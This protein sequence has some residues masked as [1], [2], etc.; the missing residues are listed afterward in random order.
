MAYDTYFTCNIEVTGTT[1]LINKIVGN[2][3]STISNNAVFSGDEQL[4]QNY[5]DLEASA[6]N[7]FVTLGSSTPLGTAAGIHCSFWLFRNGAVMSTNNVVFIDMINVQGAGFKVH[8]DQFN[9]NIRFETPANN[10]SSNQ[11]TAS[12]PENGLWAH[13]YFYRDGSTEIKVYKNG[14]VENT[15]ALVGDA[16]TNVSTLQFMFKDFGATD[17]LTGA[18]CFIDEIKIGDNF[19]D[20]AV[21]E[22]SLKDRRKLWAKFNN[23][24]NDSSGY[25]FNTIN[26]AGGSPTFVAGKKGQ[27]VD[28]DG[29]SD[30]LIFAYSGSTGIAHIVHNHSMA[31]W[32]NVDT[33]DGVIQRIIDGVNYKIFIDVNGDLQIETQL[34]FGPSDI[35]INKVI[36]ARWYHVIYTWN[37]DDL[38]LRVYID[39]VLVFREDITSNPFSNFEDTNLDIG[40]TGGGAEF[41]DGQLD[42]FRIYDFVLNETE[43]K[44]V[45][46]WK[47]VSLNNKT[48]SWYKMS[49]DIKNAMGNF[50][51][52]IANKTNATFSTDNANNGQSLLLADGFLDIE[53]FRHS[54]IHED[55]VTITFWMHKSSTSTNNITII[56]DNNTSVSANKGYGYIFIGLTGLNNNLVIRVTRLQTDT[57]S[58]LSVISPAFL[59]DD[60]LT[61][62]AV[63]V[64]YGTKIVKTWRNSVLIDTFTASAEELRTPTGSEQDI[65]IGRHG[66]DFFTGRS[67]DIEPSPNHMYMRADGTQ[68]WI[69]H[70]DIADVNDRIYEYN[71]SVAFDIT[72]ATLGNNFDTS[73]EDTQPANVYF[74]TDGAKMFVAGST[75][76]DIFEYDLGTDFDV[77]SAVFNSNLLSIAFNVLGS[78]FLKDGTKLYVFVLVGAGQYRILQYNLSSGFDITTAVDSTNIFNIATS[79]ILRGTGINGAGDRFY[80]TDRTNDD[81]KEYTFGTALDISTLSFTRNIDVSPEDGNMEG[82]FYME[83]R[84]LL[85]GVGDNNDKL[86][87]YDVFDFP[88]SSGNID[89]LRFFNQQ[90]T[91]ADLI[92]I[93]SFREIYDLRINDKSYVGRQ[94]K[95]EYITSVGF[96]SGSFKG[97]I[98]D[99]DGIITTEISNGDDV[100]IY[101]SGF[102]VFRGMLENPSR[103]K[104]KILE[105]QGRDY[106]NILFNR[107]ILNKSF[108]SLTR[109]QIMDK[110]VD[111]SDALLTNDFGPI[112]FSSSGI[113]DI[114]GETIGTPDP[115]VVDFMTVAELFIRFSKEEDAEVYVEITE[116]DPIPIRYEPKEFE[117]S[118]IEI[119][120]DTPANSTSR[121]MIRKFKFS[122]DSKQ[123]KNVFPVFGPAS[124][125]SVTIFKDLDST[126]VHGEK[127]MPAIV[128]VNAISTSLQRERAEEEKRKWE[129]ILQKGS[130]TCRDNSFLQG[131]K[132]MQVTIAEEGLNRATLLILEAKHTNRPSS[133]IL[134]VADI[135]RASEEAL[136]NLISK[137]Q[138]VNFRDADPTSTQTLVL[139]VTYTY[140]YDFIFRISEGTTL[141]QEFSAMITT[142][143]GKNAL[144]D[145]TIGIGTLLDSS[146]T[147]LALGDGTDQ[148]TASSTALG[149]EINLA[150]KLVDGGFPLDTT[151]GTAEI[152]FTISNTQL[153]SGTIRELGVFDAST[154]DTLIAVA[155][156]S[157]VTKTSGVDLNF[158]VKF[159]IN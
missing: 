44:N 110:L 47:P 70:N 17:D 102:L 137:S 33:L 69:C 152:E 78:T 7:M 116:V 147:Y 65:S 24:F 51:D 87:E 117:D 93:Q 158:I 124:S 42:D 157:P 6:T 35:I 111:G 159:T 97:M 119:D 154:G 112:A 143:V 57:S 85:Y 106:F 43:V 71:M 125:E 107:N 96:A 13:Y 141:L 128:D 121:T 63:E 22:F 155:N 123:I 148:L 138:N 94:R 41:Y 144:R 122:D 14:V 55:I 80:L 103:I 56:G 31:F 118:G 40:A 8:Y 34:T 88:D 62:V 130:L 21:K 146:N 101:Q 37:V 99:K 45:F 38:E 58:V 72:T 133:V 32:F 48:Y 19:I 15:T 59:T 86:F 60:V 12:I 79:D 132:I 10:G 108:S 134:K 23:N 4:F 150:R 104:G 140:V 76:D 115:F 135:T 126:F 49:G 64:N 2:N 66:V 75:N 53:G 89:D 151:G 120:Y 27:A 29:T 156:V 136:S 28:L 113:Q 26:V 83:S 142:R 50:N 98:Y 20:V 61:F 36:P 92:K 153:V 114:L 95:I 127:S 9:D 30:R 3:D 90:L 84:D 149:N 105:V 77:T 139:T 67:V 52:S 25:S 129:S 16:W 18:T 74:S 131:G 54:L 100:K 82:V 109:K 46:D 68:F 5:I 81:I 73:G 1:T 145:A 39:N 11:V 91:S